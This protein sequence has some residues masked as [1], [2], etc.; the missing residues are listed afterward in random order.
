MAKKQQGRKK[1][2]VISST[3]KENWE[4]LDLPLVSGLEES[5]I[6]PFSYRHRNEEHKGVT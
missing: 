5:L 1:K 4:A 3:C 2:K 6:Q